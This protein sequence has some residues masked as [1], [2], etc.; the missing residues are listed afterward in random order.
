MK[1][2]LLVLLVVPAA[3]LTLAAP[4]YS[5]AGVAQ[6]NSPTL[7]GEG[8]PEDW[9]SPKLSVSGRPEDWGSSSY[10]AQGRPTDWGS[11][12]QPQGRPEDWGSPTT[13]F[14]STLGKP[15]DWERPIRRLRHALTAFF[16]FR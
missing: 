15:E 8:H 16:Y 5:G 10:V 3:V 9:G 6:I 13:S 12:Y 11:V 14:W 1:A 2:Q 4:G 7:S